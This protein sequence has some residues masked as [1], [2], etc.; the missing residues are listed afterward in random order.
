MA[1]SKYNIYLDYRPGNWIWDYKSPPN[2][3]LG[4]AVVFLVANH[5]RSRFQSIRRIAQAM[6]PILLAGTGTRDSQPS[7]NS[8]LCTG[9]FKGLSSPPP[10]THWSQW[11]SVTGVTRQNL[12][13]A[14]SELLSPA[15]LMLLLQTPFRCW[16][17]CRLTV[18]FGFMIFQSGFLCILHKDFSVITVLFLWLHQSCYT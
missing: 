3:R 15:P 2:H 16:V 10:A 14:S 11:P 13:T 17:K 1:H 7:Y 18:W 9:T 4:W 8:Q 12:L 6:K 5:T